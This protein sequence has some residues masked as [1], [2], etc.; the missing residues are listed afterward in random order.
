[1]HAFGFPDAQVEAPPSEADQILG[2]LNVYQLAEDPVL[3]SGDTFTPDR[4]TP[5]RRLERWPDDGYPPDHACYNPFGTWHLGGAGGEADSRGDLRPVFIP[6]LVVLLAAAEEQA[7]RP[8]NREEVERLTS[9]GVCMM[10]TPADAK[11]LER[12]RGYADLEP[13]LAWRQWQVFRESQA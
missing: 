13:E 2:A 11:R 10:L 3:V 1:M 7:G 9:E 4:D 5:R 6:A 8:L 12:S